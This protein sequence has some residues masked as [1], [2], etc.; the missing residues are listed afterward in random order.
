MKNKTLFLDFDHEEEISV[1]L[2]KLKQKLPYHELFF[3]INQLNLFQF[4]RKKDL[5]VEDFSSYHSFPIFETFDELSQTTFRVMANQSCDVQ[6]KE[7]P[8]E[9]L[10]D[11]IEEEKFFIREEVD[12]IIFSKEGGNNFSAIHL[13]EEYVNSVEEYWLYP[14]EELYQTIL[15]YDE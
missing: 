3:K 2:V 15:N 11:L 9:G 14:E 7:K 6:R 1:A 8:I 10:F 13:P 5:Q 12:F 4:F